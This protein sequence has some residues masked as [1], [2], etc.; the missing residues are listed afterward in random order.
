MVF[1]ACVTVVGRYWGWW[2]LSVCC[3]ILAGIVDRICSSY[4]DDWL[5]DL[6]TKTDQDVFPKYFIASCLPLAVVLV[7]VWSEKTLAGLRWDGRCL[8][9]W[10]PA[11][12][13]LDM[14]VK[15]SA[16]PNWC[17]A[18]VSHTLGLSPACAPWML[19]V[20]LEPPSWHRWIPQSAHLPVILLADCQKLVPFIPE[21]GRLLFIWLI[22]KLSGWEDKSAAP[23]LSSHGTNSCFPWREAEQMEGRD[24]MKIKSKQ[25][26]WVFDKG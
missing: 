19:W 16:L 20:T 10:F 17:L 6:V 14:F 24:E 3:A 22:R 23:F 18:W 26:D 9:S 12:S 8:L 1:R 4:R 21:V 2:D 13:G 25:C 15:V 7:I 11:H 5:V